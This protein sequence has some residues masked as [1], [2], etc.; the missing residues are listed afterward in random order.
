MSSPKEPDSAALETLPG[1]TVVNWRQIGGGVEINAAS[2]S[3]QAERIF[4][5]AVIR[6]L[7]KLHRELEDDRQQL[8]EARRSRQQEW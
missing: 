6:L 8:L 3:H 2:W 4:V 1:S 7:A 5:P